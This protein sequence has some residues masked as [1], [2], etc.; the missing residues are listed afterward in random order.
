MVEA[1]DIDDHNPGFIYPQFKLSN[2]YMIRSYNSKDLD[3][4]TNLAW[5]FLGINVY[6]FSQVV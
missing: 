6:L 5:T 3:P 1:P 4:K 2:A